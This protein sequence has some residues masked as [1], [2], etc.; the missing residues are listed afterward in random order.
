MASRTR[1][2]SLG[3]SLLEKKIWRRLLFFL[4]ARQSFGAQVE[5]AEAI[6]VALESGR[7]GCQQSPES[8]WC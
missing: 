1:Y 5:G 3:A 8:G 2:P 4:D 6:N 7:S